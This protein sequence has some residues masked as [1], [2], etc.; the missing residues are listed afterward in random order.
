MGQPFNIPCELTVIPGVATTQNKIIMRVNGETAFEGYE[1][2]LSDGLREAVA[3]I[4]EAQA[5]LVNKWSL[6]FVR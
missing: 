6:N 1:E 3:K 2:E 4:A 5:R